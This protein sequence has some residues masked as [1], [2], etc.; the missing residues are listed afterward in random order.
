MRADWYRFEPLTDVWENPTPAHQRRGRGTFKAGHDSTMGLLRHE[1]EV[2]DPHRPWD[3]TDVVLQVACSAGDVNRDG[4]LSARARAFGHPGVRVTFKTQEHGL[5]TYE[6]DVCE[7]WQHNVRS[8][9]LGLEAL[10]A[11]KRFGIANSG[12]QY[13]GFKALPA[14]RAMPASHM[15][16]DEAL[17]VIAKIA[18]PSAGDQA[19]SDERTHALAAPENLTKLIRRAKARAHP[20]QRQ[21]NR[22]LWDALEE[23]VKAMGLSL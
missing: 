15:T 13:T 2:L 7:L 4:G 5:L 21:G 10:R 9:A 11:I 22:A 12:Q 1:I 20:D 14:G 8:I 16:R 23:A 6:S 17:K 3:Q 18:Y 19:L